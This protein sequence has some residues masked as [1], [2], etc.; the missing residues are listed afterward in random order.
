[1]AAATPRVGDLTELFTELLDLAPERFD[2]GDALPK[3]L[4][5]YVPEGRQELR[6]TCALRW[7]GAAPSKKSEPPGVDHSAAARA[8]KD[9][10]MLV[11]EVPPEVHL[12]KPETITGT[13]E[14]PAQ[15]KFERLLR[16]CHV[17]IGLLSN[18]HELRLVYAPHG[19]STGWLSFRVADMA[20]VGGRPLLDAFVMLLGRERWFS[21]SEEQALPAL[22]AKSR[23][24][25]ASVT[26]DLAGQ[27]FE[28]LEE[29]LRGF[30]DAAERAP[31]DFLREAMERGEAHVYSGLLTLLMRLV[32]CLY[33]EDR[34]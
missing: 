31:A 3:P 18:G 6:P 13:W 10:A 14:Y 27:V 23:R 17:P 29:L 34:G 2:A 5:L 21:V 32:F 20:T 28:A 7:S 33:A 24:H 19:E 30:A 15:A 1:A 16:E 12:D 9:Y 11:W 22:L 26:N 25:Q 8:G 4:R